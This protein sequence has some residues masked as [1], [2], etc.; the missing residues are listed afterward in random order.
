MRSRSS[1]FTLLE[2]LVAF[3]ALA[4]AVGAIYRATIDAQDIERR[5]IADHEATAAG[6]SLLTELTTLHR[7]QEL[8]TSGT[9]AGHWT[10]SLDIQRRYHSQVEQYRDIAGL[11]DLTLTIGA[12]GDVPVTVQTTILRRMP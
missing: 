7:P 1:G 10:W 5:S 9:Y 8:P 11:F 4:L 12:P 6:A 2:T 3:L